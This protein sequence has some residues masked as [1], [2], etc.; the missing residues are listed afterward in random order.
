MNTKHLLT[1][2]LGAALLYSWSG[3]AQASLV[4]TTWN[5]GSLTTSAA[6]GGVAFGTA[7]VSAD[8]RTFSMT[9]D[10]HEITAKA[11]YFTPS[12]GFAGSKS[13]TTYTFDPS[14]A[15]A[16]G[17]FDQAQ[18]GFISLD[19]YG[20]GVCDGASNGQCDTSHSND[21]SGRLDSSGNFDVL[22]LTLP[23]TSWQVV[24]TLLTFID[25]KDSYI[26]KGTTDPIGD[27]TVATWL[28]LPNLGLATPGTGNSSPTD[29]VE[30]DFLN[31]LPELNLF[32]S[33]GG[34]LSTTC[35]TQTVKKATVTSCNG[36][37]ADSDFR[38]LSFSG[39]VTVTDPVVL[40]DVAAVP[41]PASLALFGAGAVAFG[42][43][44]R[45][46]RS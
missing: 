9:V 46:R 12:T 23:G 38:V 11:W 7:G 27:L 18:Q 25:S 29:G 44:R 13:G 28:G 17:A 39:E 37:S 19:K 42:V 6:D 10:N 45:R 30:V 4:T 21:N 3:D 5:F 43:F 35:T 40:R 8:G 26:V 36:F 41:E 16:G 14:T 24:N 33:A 1:T 34:P 31:N 22:Q 32:I 20:L 2:A 15:T